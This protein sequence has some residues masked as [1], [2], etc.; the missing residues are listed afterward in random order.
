MRFGLMIVQAVISAV[1]CDTLSFDLCA[2]CFG[3]NDS[4]YILNFDPLY[5][6]QEMFTIE[7][8]FKIFFFFFNLYD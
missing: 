6:T 1:F 4:S 7:N 3:D 2:R 5:F 8:N